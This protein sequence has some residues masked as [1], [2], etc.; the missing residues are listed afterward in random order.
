MIRL[1]FL[2]FFISSFAQKTKTLEGKIFYEG[3]PISAA[4]IEVKSGNYF[5]NT[6]SDDLGVFSIYKIPDSISKVKI[7]ISHLQYEPIVK[8]I[9]ISDRNNNINFN[10]ERETV[11]SMKEIIV[12]GVPKKFITQDSDKTVISVR[13]ND[14]LNTGNTFEAI[15]KLPG[16]IITSDGLI[17]QNGKLSTIFIDGEPTG[18]FSDNLVVFLNSLPANSIDKIE[19]IPNPGAKYQATFS[20]GIIN[21][22][23]NS[24]K[25]KGYS[26]SI[27]SN[28]RINHNFK[29]SNSAQIL[30]KKNKLNYNVFIGSN[31]NVS[32]QR[33][34]FKTIFNNSEDNIVLNE[35]RSPIFNYDGYYIRNNLKY[36]FSKKT[37][38]IFNYNLNK[39]TNKNLY[40]YENYSENLP[41][42][43]SS[44]TINDNNR[45]NVNNE[46]IVKLKQKIDTIGSNF[47]LTIYSNFFDEK[48]SNKLNEISTENRYSYTK[49]NTST[50]NFNIR[51][52]SEFPFKR[53]KMILYSG[54]S[55]GVFNAENSGNYILNS[56]NPN[57]FNE[58]VFEEFIPF[59]F[60]NKNYSL[61]S[62]INKKINKLSFSLGIR[63]ENI[64]YEGF[65][66]NSLI[67]TKETYSNFFPNTNILYKLNDVIN[68]S[69][70]YNR[71]IN[72]PNYSSFDPNNN[73]SSFYYNNTGN[74]LLIP[75]FSNNF[76]WKITFFDYAYLSY[77]K[78]YLSNRNVPFY[79][80]NPN[81]FGVTQSLISLENTNNQNINLGIPIPFAL[82]YKGLSFIE[83]KD[84][85]NPNNISYLF[86]DLS[87]NKT[88]FNN[89]LYSKYEKGNFM[90]YLYSQIVLLDNL[91]MY[92]NYNYTSKGSVD[93]YN[94]NEPIQNLDVHLST[95]FLK[96]KL[97]LNVGVLNM[98]NTYGFNANFTGNQI[99]SH[100]NRKNET[101]MFRIS[102]TYNFGT[103]KNDDN[104]DFKENNK[105][106]IEQ[107]K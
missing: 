93:I 29:S 88:I 87:Y 62:S 37:S 53:N 7:K 19:L 12:T 21:I 47:D 100:Y 91:K 106:T 104:E 98:L 57:I 6:V 79:S 24:L 82:F 38:L 45:N 41:T 92:V 103:F 3:L 32:D 85:V 1:F 84:S 72:L 43:F 56:L 59:I 66:K 46:I 10:F 71:K 30:I 16:V 27:N 65:V 34:T 52:D 55:A 60:E 25:S 17:G 86:A 31:N 39:N 61:Y 40:R 80:T 14:F 49:F 107:V 73:L 51:L 95:K 11:I 54:F 35:N 74:P 50:N 97:I 102:L 9:F 83:N 77:S 81:S 78:S 69:G 64:N 18:L 67:N 26:V 20:G 94:L 4:F 5:Q 13:N 75:E 22:I 36:T 63:Y 89:E 44:K 8:E 96:Q 90:L 68:I 42:D 48:R 15:S 28:N 105:N 101:R 99:E 2:L 70:S 58:S 76:N 23:T 33:E